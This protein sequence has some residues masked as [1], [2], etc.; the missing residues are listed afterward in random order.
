LSEEHKELAKMV[1]TWEQH[2]RMR[3]DP[4]GPW[5]ETTGTATKKLILGG[6]YIQE[7]SS[8]TM[9]GMPMQ[10]MELLGYDKLTH[11]YVSLW[12]D[13]MTTW[14]TE[15]RGKKDAKGDVDLRGT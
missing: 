9:E 8:F 3:W 11:E 4:N 1:G 2:F 7:D 15:S 12:A 13:T 5:Q 6:R 10:G 14:W